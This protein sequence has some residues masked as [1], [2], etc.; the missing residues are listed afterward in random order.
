M[1]QQIISMG[2]NG[3]LSSASAMDRQDVSG[4][5]CSLPFRNA[6]ICGDTRHREDRAP[7]S[8]V[9]EGGAPSSNVWFIRTG[10]LRLQRY[11][12]DG[13]RQIMSL[14]FPG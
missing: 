2:S 8:E 6:M 3:E 1:K 14:F 7:D 10:I 12:Y 9:I 4:H 5:R 13:R 11:A